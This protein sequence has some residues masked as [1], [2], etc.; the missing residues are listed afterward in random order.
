MTR[1]RPAQL[2]EVELLVLLATA[3]LAPR[4]ETGA[5]PAIV[6][7]GAGLFEISRLLRGRQSN[8]AA[9]VVV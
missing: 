6:T 4:R 9:D 2:A 5:E 8:S 7:V 1:R 3:D